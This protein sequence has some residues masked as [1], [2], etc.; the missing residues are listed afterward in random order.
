M[1]GKLRRTRKGRFT[2]PNIG[3]NPVERRYASIRAAA[4]YLNIHPKTVRDWIKAGR[5]PVYRFT[6]RCIR[7]DL[8]E[9]DALGGAR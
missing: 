5:V 2:L 6:D 7:V 3:T 8:N 1:R 9:L 4:N